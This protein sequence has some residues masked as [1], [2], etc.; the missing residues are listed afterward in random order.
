MANTNEISHYRDFSESL[1]PAEKSLSDHFC[2]RPFEHAEIMHGHGPEQAQGFGDVYV[3]CSGWLSKKIGNYAQDALQTIWNSPEALEIRESIIDGSFRFCNRQTCHYILKGSLPKRSFLSPK[4]Q[5]IIKN[6]ELK[7][8]VLPSSF[9]LCYDRSC[10]LACPS[11]RNELVNFQSGPGFEKPMQLNEKL[12]QD[13]FSKPTDRKI[14]LK[15]TGSGDPFASAAFSSL[16]EKLDGRKFPGLEI[17]LYTNGLLFTPE[18]WQKLEHIWNHVK[19]VSV[20]IDAAS[21]EVYKKTRGGSWQQLMANM[22]FIAQLR[23]QNVIRHFA[24]NYVVQTNNFLDT[25][26]FVKLCLQ[27]G[28]DLVNFSFVSDWS[29]WDKQEFKGH[30]IWQKDHP[31]FYD[32]LKVLTD[33]VFESSIVALGPL[34]PYRKLALAGASVKK[35]IS[36][37]LS[38]RSLEKEDLSDTL[39]V[40]WKLGLSVVAQKYFEALKNA[41]SENY[42]YRR[43]SFYNFAGEYYSQER[44]ITVLNQSID[45]INEKYPGS[46]PVKAEVG[47]SQEQ[48]N[49][50]HTYFE[51]FRGVMSK[52]HPLYQ[53]GSIEL[54]EAFDNLNIMIHRYE[55]SGY[56][57]RQMGVG[58]PKFYLIF[59]LSEKI[60]RYPLAEEDYQEFTFEHK[61]GDL[62]VNYCEVG[63]PLHDVWRDGDKEIGAEAILPLRFYSADGLALFASEVDANLSQSFKAEFNDWWDLHASRLA[64]LGF[65]KNDPRNAVGH[66]VVAELD[67]EQALLKG[68]SDSEICELLSDYQWVSK[69][70]CL[71]D[72]VVYGS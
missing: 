31:F 6:K 36:I 29:T 15:I 64:E 40:Q 69:V 14:N 33:P 44:I 60:K 51:K 41:V 57:Q 2:Y 71:E 21:A 39:E 65:V 62:L 4:Y 67:R 61:F 47:M 19:V 42:M 63:K 18:H 7:L 27:F 70:Q 9:F 34:A 10:N 37:F 28:V 48:M 24:T 68:R 66:L 58:V 13:L 26:D 16:L 72:G 35:R 49:H 59:G 43:D 38:R 55:D 11:C 46:I 30:C 3:C 56:S 12:M 22:E 45:V 5:N 23:R 17:E 8:D 54:R 53:A 20:S 50:L 52:P 1:I 25:A 32:F